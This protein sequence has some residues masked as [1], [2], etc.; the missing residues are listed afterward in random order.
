[1]PPTPRRDLSAPPIVIGAGP[2]GLAAA[3]LLN[4]SGEPTVILERSDRV[5]ASWA[6]RYDHLRLHTTPGTSKLPGLSVP[7]QAGPWVSRDDY[8]RYLERYV[9][10]HRLDVRLTTPVERIERAEPGSG[11]QWLVH[12][13]DGPLPTGAVVVATGRCHTPNLPRW[14]GRSMFT[15]TLLH[16]AHYRSP[17]PYRGRD[18]LVVGAGNSGTEIA[19]VLAGAGA[20]RVRIAVRTPPNILPRSSARWH[21]AG[22]LTEALPLRWRDRTS[23]LTQRLAVPDL[24]SRGLS[25]PCIGLYT[26][27]AHEGINPVLDHGFVDAV[28][29]GRVDPVAAVQ[30]FDGPDVILTDGTRLRPDTV[31]AATGYRPNLHD[32][33]GSLGV[34][35]EDGHPLTVGAQ[36]HPAAPRL[37]FAG[38]TNPLTGVLRQAGI[39][40]RA[41]AQALRREKARATLHTPQLGSFP[42]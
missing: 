18:V 35:D 12:T 32:L 4:R 6:Q 16:S 21:A 42:A 15:G 22:R 13:P 7:R 19:S 37:Y 3:A 41:I 36:T 9:A 25:R 40:A 29:S 11:A 34:L 26:R 5:G 30:A 20:G 24:T 23:L 33:V 27:N 17:A 14:P 2:H 10:H 39:E 1:M 8:V 31:I 38:Y 28:R